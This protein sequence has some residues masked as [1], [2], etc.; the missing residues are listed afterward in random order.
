[1][2]ALLVELPSCLLGECDLDESE[3]VLGKPTA[4]LSA[5]V[6]AFPL[7]R[8]TI[9][10][11]ILSTF[12]ETRNPHGPTGRGGSFRADRLRTPLW[13]ACVELE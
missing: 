13:T 10:A 2:A 6:S 4:D 5:G 11:W 7:Y 3:L 8:C 12:R 1:M 9:L